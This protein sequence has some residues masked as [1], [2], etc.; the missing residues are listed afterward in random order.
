[1]QVQHAYES[2]FLLEKNPALADV[3][4]YVFDSLSKHHLT[5]DNTFALMISCGKDVYK[6][7]KS[8]ENTWEPWKFLTKSNKNF[9][10]TGVLHVSSIILTDA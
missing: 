10:F 1:M 6:V 2:Y 5:R 3:Q 4:R 8:K 9:H 7:E